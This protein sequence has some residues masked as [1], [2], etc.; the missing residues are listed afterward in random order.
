MVDDAQEHNDSNH[1]DT[2]DYMNSVQPGHS[3]VESE[4][5]LCAPGIDRW[6]VCNHL[7]RRPQAHK[8]LQINTV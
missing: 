7:N 8:P 3:K 2:D 5:Q 6:I 4:K 1:Q